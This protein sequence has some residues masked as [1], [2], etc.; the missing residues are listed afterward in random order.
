MLKRALSS[1][2]LD[3]ACG[4]VWHAGWWAA[5]R[6]RLEVGDLVGAV[7]ALPGVEAHPLSPL[8]MST[9]AEVTRRRLKWD[10][11]RAR[12]DESARLEEVLGEAPEPWV[13][14]N[15]FWLDAFF[16][17][18]EQPPCSTEIRRRAAGSAFWEAAAAW[19]DAFMSATRL[20]R[21]T[22]ALERARL[23]AAAALRRRCRGPR[24]P[25]V[26]GA[27]GEPPRVRAAGH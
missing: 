19:C 18:A 5:L 12:Q 10:D 16:L 3:A 1:G 2:D 27:L 26:D 21:C 4:L 7:L 23:A 17:D 8:M 22:V 11:S 25:D 15:R 24:Q 14:Y 6:D 9:A 13:P 20:S